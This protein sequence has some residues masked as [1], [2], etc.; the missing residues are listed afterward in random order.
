MDF[1]F[2]TAENLKISDEEIFE[3]LTQVYVDGGFTRPELA[4]T[5]FDPASVRRR[6]LLFGVRERESSE[7][8]GII[9][10]VS[11]ES[12]ASRL[13]VGRE[14]EIHLLGVK[15]KYRG[16]GLAR[17]LV[18]IL[19]SLAKNQRCSKIILW[20]QPTMEAAQKL[21]VSLGFLYIRDIEFSG[22]KF[23]IYS[24]DLQPDH[25]PSIE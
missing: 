16:M 18:E 19:I 4:Q 5:L 13:A 2:D 15:S 20:T 7:L 22:R 6:G 14:V 10:L 1:E 11:P 24:C 17:K 25:R 21:Y 8:A 3:L 9:I 23:L 12:E